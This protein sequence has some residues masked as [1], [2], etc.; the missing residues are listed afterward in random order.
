L[1][2]VDAAAATTAARA[3]YI[4]RS[5]I[6]K[7]CWLSLRDPLRSYGMTD[8]VDAVEAQ[9]KSDFVHPE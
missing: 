5:E 7:N 2:R 6:F 9:V 1:E 3:A 4:D 8:Y